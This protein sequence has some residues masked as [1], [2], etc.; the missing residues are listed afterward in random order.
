MMRFFS[1][2]AWRSISCFSASEVHETE[3]FY[4]SLRGMLFNN[5]GDKNAD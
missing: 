5:N 1:G 3:R 2:A 4:G